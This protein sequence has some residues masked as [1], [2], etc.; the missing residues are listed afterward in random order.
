MSKILKSQ[1]K[2]GLA[3]MIGNQMLAPAPVGSGKP[4]FALV[5]MVR[6]SIAA[7]STPP[8]GGRREVSMPLSPTPCSFLA[9]PGAKK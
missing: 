9:N 7:G 8:G 5:A 6:T 2:T 4:S 1:G 3:P